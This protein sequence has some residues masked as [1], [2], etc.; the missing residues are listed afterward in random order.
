MDPVTR[1]KR[2]EESMRSNDL[3][4][5]IHYAA[6]HLEPLEA[7]WEPAQVEHLIPEDFRAFEKE[8]GYPMVGVRYYCKRGFS[9][10]TPAWRAVLANGVFWDGE[11]PDPK[12]PYGVLF[13]GFDLADVEGWAFREGGD[14]GI[15]VWSVESS[16]LDERGAGGFTEWL[17][18]RL[19]GL[20]AFVKDPRSAAELTEGREA[21]EADPHRLIDY[22]AAHPRGP[23]C[24]DLCALTT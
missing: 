19:A 5:S 22:S 13:A 20:E 6:R 23:G 18:Q 8:I 12:E 15:E 4:W 9:I 10:L 16:S 21:G 17:D 14:G 2:F 11:E 3:G 7:P 1:W 24:N